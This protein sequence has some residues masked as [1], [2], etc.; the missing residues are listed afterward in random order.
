MASHAAPMLPLRSRGPEYR[1]RAAEA[2][3]K[4][5]SLEDEGARRT[6]LNSADLWDRMADYEERQQAH[7]DKD[8][9]PA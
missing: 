8:Q 4:A 9:A 2:R 6:M 1:E 5:E 3:I 7:R